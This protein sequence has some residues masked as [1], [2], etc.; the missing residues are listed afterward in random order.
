M[1]D[2]TALDEKPVK[3]S[4]GSGKR[5]TFGNWLKIPRATITK[6]AVKSTRNS[7]VTNKKIV[8]PRTTNIKIISKFSSIGIKSTAPINVTAF[9]SPV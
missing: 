2:N 8:T 6:I 1:I 9:F 7:S 3:R 5:L 4:E